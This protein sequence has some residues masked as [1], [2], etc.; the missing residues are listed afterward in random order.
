M[1]AT[2]GQ[3]TTS[4]SEKAEGH[5]KTWKDTFG[6]GSESMT[7]PGY[8]SHRDVES[9]TS[10]RVRDEGVWYTQKLQKSEISE[11][12]ST[13]ILLIFFFFLFLVLS[14]HWGFSYVIN[15]YYINYI[16]PGHLPPASSSMEFMALR[17]DVGGFLRGPRQCPE[18]QP[19]TRWRWR[20]V[21]LTFGN[22]WAWDDGSNS[23]NG[24]RLVECALENISPSLMSLPRNRTWTRLLPDWLWMM[25][26][27]VP[28]KNNLKHLETRVLMQRCFMHKVYR[29][30]IITCHSLFKPPKH[31]VPVTWQPIWVNGP[32]EGI[33]AVDLL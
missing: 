24:Y 22:F 25:M 30:D 15:Y 5:G 8:T 29:N 28:V 7:C 3:S 27:D 13:H 4:Q 11:M 31:P 18:V 12:F 19:A 33:V 9:R 10:E 17:K 2:W 16:F 14:F 6:T 32:S 26:M 21:A 23:A 20:Q 1:Q